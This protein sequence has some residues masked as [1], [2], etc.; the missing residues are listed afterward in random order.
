MGFI[1]TGEVGNIDQFVLHSLETVVGV[2]LP[3]T[4]IILSSTVPG[5]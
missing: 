1:V 5:K 2:N 3:I 4:I